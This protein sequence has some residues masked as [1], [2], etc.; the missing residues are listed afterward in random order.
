VN[1][2]NLPFDPVQDWQ[3]APRT[4][5]GGWY[6]RRGRWLVFAGVLLA[7]AGLL[8]MLRAQRWSEA[9]SLPERALVAVWLMP[10]PQALP[11]P[12]SPP[13]PRSAPVTIVP[14]QSPA[15]RRARSAPPDPAPAADASAAAP[16]PD[17][18]LYGRDGRLLL[19]D[20]I[21]A[22]LRAVTDPRARFDF[23]HPGLIEARTRTAPPPALVYEATRFDKAWQNETDPLSAA[24][25]KVVETSTITVRIP[26]PRSP[27]SKLVCTLALAAASGGCGIRS[28]SDG[29]VVALDDPATLDRREDAQCQAWWDAMAQ[30]RTESQWETARRQYEAQCRKPRMQAAAAPP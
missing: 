15:L 1:Y 16:V 30:A 24:L 10:S 6:E 20:T 17:A 28:L 2:E 5:S 26:L 22:D 18:R 11:S 19:P 9:P 7:H 3:P 25:Q 14:A 29:Y 13:A 27:G 21:D 23:R 8:Q 12:P 4:A